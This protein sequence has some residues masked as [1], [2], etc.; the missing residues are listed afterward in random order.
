VSIGDLDVAIAGGH[1]KVARRLTRLLAAH[2]DRVRALIRNPQHAADVE[3]D[4]A[5]AV[6]VDIETASAAELASA[7]TGADA[8]VFAA[9][10]GPGSGPER[11]WT[12]DAGAAIRLIEAA[13]TAD[14]DRYVMISSIGAEDPPDGDDGWSAYLQ[15]KAHADQALT[16]SDL[17]WTIVRPVVMNDDPGRGLVTVDVSPLE[18]EISRDDVAATLNEVLHQ[19]RSVHLTFYVAAGDEPIDRA[20][21]G[22]LNARKESR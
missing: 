15:A 12:I 13:K 10:A 9:G 22:L 17:A 11:K 21:A 16:A 5:E 1:G 19:R 2:G 8:V 3:S 20:L 6:V 14:V 18:G 4:G 7:I